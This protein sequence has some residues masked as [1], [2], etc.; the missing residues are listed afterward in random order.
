MAPPPEEPAPDDC[1][2]GDGEPWP[3]HDW[4]GIPQGESGECRRCGAEL[5]D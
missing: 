1:L 5:V 3:E 4:T 2:D